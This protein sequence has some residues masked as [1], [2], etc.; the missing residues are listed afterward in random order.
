MLALALIAA[1][2]A[3]G[4]ARAQSYDELP[5]ELD[6]RAQR[7]YGAIMCPQCAGQSLD[8]SNSPIARTMRQTIR[9]QLRGGASDDE[10]IDL[11]ATAYGEEILASP[12]TRGFSL[13]AWAVPPIALLLGGA[14]VAVAVRSLRRRPDAPG[15]PTA[16]GDSG[17]EPY[18]DIVDR[19]LANDTPRAR[20]GGH[21]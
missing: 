21:G 13:A 9:E 11:L 12:P 1:M 4:A 8:Q 6:Q 7:L 18:L 19:E 14:A 17:L 3:A 10:I 15:E 16:T 5:P 2:A 20:G